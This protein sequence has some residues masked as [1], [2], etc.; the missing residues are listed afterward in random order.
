MERRQKHT[1]AHTQ[2]NARAASYHHKRP[3]PFFCTHNT[4]HTRTHH[5][6]HNEG[7]RRCRW[8]QQPQQ[9]RAESN[10]KLIELISICLYL[11]FSF[12]FLS[13]FLS[14]NNFHNLIYF[15]H[16][17]CFEGISS[18]VCFF[19]YSIYSF[20]SLTS[21]IPVLTSL[22]LLLQPLLL[23]H[24]FGNDGRNGVLYAAMHF[25]IIFLSSHFVSPHVLF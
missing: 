16:L 25:K 11:S 18:V 23:F 17:I 2:S 5:T 10:T 21:L 12:S 9:S 13:V 1:D 22:L 4:A 20:L 6:T 3:P 8:R 19:C 24:W 14:H 7:R 15:H